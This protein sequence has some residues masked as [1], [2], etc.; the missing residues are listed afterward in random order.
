MTRTIIFNSIKKP[1][2]ELTSADITKIKIL[3]CKNCIYASRSGYNPSDPDSAGSLLCD[4]I[5]ITGH[6]R[7]CRPDACD[8]YTFRD[9]LSVS[10]T[11]K[12]WIGG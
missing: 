7:G 3:Q 11:K 9:R 12:F 8:K 5:G 2:S 1:W 10:R 6:R 4:Y